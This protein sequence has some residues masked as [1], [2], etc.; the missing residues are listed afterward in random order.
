M[1]TA[2][3]TVVSSVLGSVMKDTVIEE[4]RCVEKTWLNWWDDLKNKVLLPNTAAATH[5]RFF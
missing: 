1:C 4:K 2:T 3:T 5:I